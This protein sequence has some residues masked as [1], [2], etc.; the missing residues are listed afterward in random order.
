MNEPRPSDAAFLRG[1]TSRRLSRRDALRV[2]GISA[3]A[4]ALA[5]CGVKG[6]GS[7]ATTPAADAVAKFWAGKTKNGKLDFASWP[8]YMDPKKPEL[9]AFT[10]ETGITVNY[11]E[12]IQEM[13]PWFAKVQ[14]QLAANQ[15]IGFDLMLITNGIQFK[16]FV[17]SKFLA[18]LDHSKLTNFAAHAGAA[19][20]KT[21]YDPGNIYSV[22]WASG[23]TGI[24]YDPAKVKE[25]ITKLADLWNPAYKGKVGMFSDTQELA[26]FGLLA[27]GVDPAKSTKADWQKAAD[28]LKEQKAAGIVRKYYDQSY[29]DALGSGEVWIT[30]AWSGDI[31]QKNASDGANFKFVIPEEGGTI[32]T[33]NFA[34][35]VTAANPVD[36]IMAIDFFYRPEIAATLAEFI[37]Y[38][39]P[40]PDAQALIQKHADADTTD[41][42]ARLERIAKSPLVFPD[43][44]TYAK[45]HYYVDFPDAA[46]QQ[47]FQSIFEPLVLS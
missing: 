29:V 35:P 9:A 33:D 4:L 22:P 15:P 24:A 44:A 11:Q 27:T 8:L 31:L 42:K 20:R 41:Q 43:A 1:L 30:Q 26:N 23:M 12:V 37:G 28:K 2:S 47:Q 3:A 7:A 5:A 32:W 38:V 36:A 46:T 18:P 16:Q 17:Q 34:I 25:P 14:P 13:G 45:L 19:Y 21:T 39:T 10:K 6:Q 40:V